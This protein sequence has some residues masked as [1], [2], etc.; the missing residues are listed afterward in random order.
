MISAAPPTGASASTCTALYLYL[1][2]ARKGLDLI[3]FLLMDTLMAHHFKCPAATSL[4]NRM[5]HL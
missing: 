3:Y 5:F 2:R 1:F 4:P